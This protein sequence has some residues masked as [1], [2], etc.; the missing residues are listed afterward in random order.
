[1]LSPLASYLTLSELLITEKRHCVLDLV[2]N[3]TLE[4]IYLTGFYLLN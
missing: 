1:M 4:I 3:I 2:I